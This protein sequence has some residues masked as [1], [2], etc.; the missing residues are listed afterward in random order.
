MLRKISGPCSIYIH[1]DAVYVFEGARHD[2]GLECF[3][4]VSRPLPYD[5]A[6]Y[7]ALDRTQA[8]II[9]G[10]QASYAVPSAAVPAAGSKARNWFV[11]EIIRAGSDDW[12]ADRNNR[13]ESTL[14]HITRN[15][16]KR[17][18]DVLR[19]D[20][21]EDLVVPPAHEEVVEDL[22]K[23][24]LEKMRYGDGGEEERRCPACKSI[25]RSITTPDGFRHAQRVWYCGHKEEAR[26]CL[27]PAGEPCD[28]N[29]PVRERAKPCP[30]CN[31]LRAVCP[32]VCGT[33]LVEGYPDSASQWEK[34][35][36]QSAVV[37]PGPPPESQAEIDRFKMREGGR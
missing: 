34:D 14:V 31:T 23:R 22:L 7:P 18:S 26:E 35:A 17:T 29:P 30:K 27:H 6:P 36:R 21:D 33:T 16:K 2:V 8:I 19:R 3:S 20:H 5:K 25:V 28:E 32:A 4:A 9:D 10:G 12:V 15:A 37:H 13:W 1:E 11:T 24:K